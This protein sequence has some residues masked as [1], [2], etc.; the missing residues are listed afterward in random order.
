[1]CTDNAISLILHVVFK[2][3]SHR[4]GCHTEQAKHKWYIIMR[5]MISTSHIV[6]ICHHPK[7]LELKN[8]YICYSTIMHNILLGTKEWLSYF[9]CFSFF[10]NHNSYCS[11]Q[12]NIISWLTKSL[13]KSYSAEIIKR[14]AKWGLCALN[15]ITKENKA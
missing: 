14:L 11:E 10:H 1:M 5:F 8:T 3:P 2:R 7:S 9:S 15:W 4:P 12:G 6:T 13:M